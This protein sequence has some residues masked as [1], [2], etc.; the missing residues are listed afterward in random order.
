MAR[1]VAAPDR[2]QAPGA[3]V[4]RLFDL[5][6]FVL[7]TCDE[8]LAVANRQEMSRPLHRVAGPQ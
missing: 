2:V 6:C 3:S 1:V 4:Q 8:V 5:I 7:E